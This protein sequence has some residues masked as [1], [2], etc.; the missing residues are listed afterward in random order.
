[1]KAEYDF[2]QAVATANFASS[3]YHAHWRNCEVCQYAQV[4]EDKY[5]RC[6][7]GMRL[8][9]NRSKWMRRCKYAAKREG[10]RIT[11]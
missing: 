3:Q 1:M 8:Y 6:Y 10:K 7:D 4:Y 2:A 5:L 9:D 11:V